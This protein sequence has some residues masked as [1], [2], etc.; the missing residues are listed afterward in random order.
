MKILLGS[1]NLYPIS[2]HEAHQPPGCLA[3]LYT[4]KNIFIAKIICSQKFFRKSLT[5]PKTVKQ[6]RNYPIPYLNALN[7]TIPYLNTLSR[8]IPYLNTLSRTIHYINK[9]NRT[10]PYRITLNPTLIHGS[11]STS[12]RQPIRFEYYVT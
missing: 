1:R 12:T 8:T 9:L 4:T 6:C 2:I 11:Q 10:I 3:R 7:Q 5:V